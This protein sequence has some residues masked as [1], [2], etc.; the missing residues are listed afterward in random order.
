[1]GCNC[2]GNTNLSPSGEPIKLSLT[3]NI[4]TYS[5]KFFGFLL[6]LI[7]LPIINLGII[8]YVFKMLVLNKEINMIPAL[9][10]L[11]NK[12]KNIDDDEYDDEDDEE[13]DELTEDDVELLHVEEITNATK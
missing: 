7:L 13:F 8:F 9:Y 12:A 10:K 4:F 5:L 3:Q 2:K 11:L 6:F 1:M